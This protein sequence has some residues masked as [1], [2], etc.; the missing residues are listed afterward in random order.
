MKKLIL[1]GVLS[2]VATGA[3][4]LDKSLGDSSEYYQSPLEDHSPGAKSTMLGPEHGHGD[5]VVRDYTK[6][7]HDGPVMKH[8]QA[9][10]EGNSNTNMHDH[11]D[12]VVDN[13][14]P[15]PHN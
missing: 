8:P 12:N 10:T 2:L 3:F 5:D 7:G 6:H 13:F 4:A 14:T 15:H 9:S 11:G 1:A